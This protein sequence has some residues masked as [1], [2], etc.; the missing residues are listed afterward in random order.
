MA[1]IFAGGLPTL[2]PRSTAALQVSRERDWRRRRIA[3]AR[4]LVKCDLNQLCT[5]DLY[6]KGAVSNIVSRWVTSTS[7]ASMT[8]VFANLSAPPLVRSATSSMVYEM[9]ASIIATSPNTNIGVIVSP[10]RTHQ[11]GTTYR[12]ENMIAE[13]IASN[14]LDIDRL[15]CLVYD[16][17]V[18]STEERSIIYQ[19]RLAVAMG[20][21]L[22]NGP[23]RNSGLFV[24]SPIV[25]P[26]PTL[27]T[28][29]MVQIED[30]AEEVLPCAADMS[31][32]EKVVQLGSP[33]TSAIF[34]SLFD[35]ASV[36][37]RCFSA[38]SRC[39]QRFVGIPP[40]FRREGEIFFS[41]RHAP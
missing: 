14:G 30:P 3:A 7:Q 4:D 16:P 21:D 40:R 5:Y 22:R 23:W 25:G 9:T 27:S 15:W 39:R 37:S 2:L 38:H 33:A 18:N 24:K 41:I 1:A 34:R 12:A 32:I 17:H 10:C 28:K 36:D 26:I 29:L 31:Q 13:K 11:S 20:S 8:V 6:E 19:G 35:G